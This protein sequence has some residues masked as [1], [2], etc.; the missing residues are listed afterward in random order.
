MTVCCYYNTVAQEEGDLRL[1][2]T[3]STER[4]AGRLEIYYQFQWGTV[5]D[6]F[7]GDLE[8]DIACR[9]LGYPSADRYGDVDD[10]G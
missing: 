9:Q 7:F 3:S 1:V 4:G 5:C 10:L 6:D 2:S 8:A